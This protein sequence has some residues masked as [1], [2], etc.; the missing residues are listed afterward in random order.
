MNAESTVSKSSSFIVSQLGYLQKCSV[1]QSQPFCPSITISQQTGSGAH[2]IAELTAEVLQQTGPNGMKPWMV[3]DRQ[4]LE[5]VLEEHQ[6]PK[7]FAKHMPEDRRSYIQ[8]VTDELLGL[9]PPSWELVPKVVETILHLVKMGYVIVVGRGATVIASRMPGVFHV[10]LVA[11]LPRRIERVQQL[12][13]LSRQEAASF[14]EKEDRG[15]RRYVKAHFHTRIE[16]ELL[17][18]LVI[19]TD[20][21]SYVEAAMLIA[22]GARRCFENREH[23]QEGRPRTSDALEPDSIGQE[24]GIKP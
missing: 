13:Q 21:V 22:N 15:S 5:K 12:H 11:S 1:A 7:R 17:Y 18:H 23:F 3:F 24:R 10:R 8:D 19:N 14:V 4:L 16:D 20:R 2:D 9:R 6:L